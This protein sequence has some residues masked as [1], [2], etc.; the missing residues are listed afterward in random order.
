MRRLLVFVPMYNCE[1][2]I[3]RVL[4]QFDEDV[5]ASFSELIVVDNRSSDGSVEAATRAMRGLRSLPAR[6]LQNDGNY[7]LGGSHKVAFDYALDNGFEHC[8][9]LHGDDQGSIRDL[10]PYIRRGVHGE[11]DC[12][13]GARFMRGARLAGYSR[14]RRFG[15]LAFNSMYSAACGRRL[16]DLGSGLNLYS[17]VALRDRFYRRLADDLTF[18]YTMILASV[19][20][21][22][23][24]EFFPVS[25]REDDQVSNVKLLRQSAKTVQILARFAVDRA[26]FMAADHSS[27]GA[28]GY[29]WTLLHDTRAERTASRP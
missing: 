24:I 16:F 2:Q 29:T 14:F 21:K 20:R 8:V 22:W 12:L 13:L 11:V 10:L 23:R 1:R 4:A 7:G 9:V 17:V 15:N 6:L 5:C 27:R 3:G 19:A 18:N 28:T 26:G 25:W